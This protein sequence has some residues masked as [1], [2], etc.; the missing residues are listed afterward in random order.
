MREFPPTPG[1]WFCKSGS[2]Y[3]TKNGQRVCIAFMDRN[4]PGTRPTERDSN[5]HLIAKTPKLLAAAKNL[6]AAVNPDSL[7]ALREVIAEAE[8]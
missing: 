1:P 3:A 2:V 5:A 8:E 4:E 6:C 7:R